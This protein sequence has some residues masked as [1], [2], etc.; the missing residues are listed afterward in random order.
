M[1][2]VIQRNIGMLHARKLFAGDRMRSHKHANLVFQHAPRRIHD[3]ALGRAHIHHQSLRRDDVFDALECGLGGRYRHGDQHDIRARRSQQ[4]R[5]GLDID[6]THLHGAL[7]GGWRFAVT[8]D[9][10]DQTGFFHRQCK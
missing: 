1:F 10:L 2:V 8:N 6:H 7:R 4:S 5:R 9:P 3:I